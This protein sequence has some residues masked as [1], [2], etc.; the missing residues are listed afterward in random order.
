MLSTLES[1]RADQTALR[2]V[3]SSG[4][5]LDGVVARCDHELVE[6]RHGDGSRSV[7]RLAHI[8]AVTVR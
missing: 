6:L 5:A 2:V 4:T 3:L 8:I 1:A 7:I